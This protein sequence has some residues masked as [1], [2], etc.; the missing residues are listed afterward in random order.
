MILKASLTGGLSVK[1]K[2]MDVWTVSGLSPGRMCNCTTMSVFL[3]RTHE[4]LLASDKGV[5]LVPIEEL[6]IGHGGAFRQCHPAEARLGVLRIGLARE[7]VLSI[8]IAA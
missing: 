6:A 5:S 4:N 7:G 2:P 1:N 3:L 8:R